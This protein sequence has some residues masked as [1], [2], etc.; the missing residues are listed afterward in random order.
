[1]IAAFRRLRVRPARPRDAEAVARIVQ[2][3]FKEYRRGE[4]M[5]LSARLSADKVRKQLVRGTKEYAVARFGEKPV[6][7]IGVRK[8]GRVLAFGPVGVLPEHRAQGV[9]SALLR[10]AEQRA[11]AA[12][13]RKLKAE[14]LWGLEALV[15]YYRRRGFEIERTPEGKIMAVKRLGGRRR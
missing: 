4:R 7:A 12:G 3:S 5:P 14:I 11:A 8:K 10:W 1:M 15:R 6:G 9:G 2:E 13:C